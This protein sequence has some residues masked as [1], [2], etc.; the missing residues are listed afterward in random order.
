[1]GAVWSRPTIQSSPASLDFPLTSFTLFP[2]LQPEVRS[3][4]WRHALPGPRWFEF[5]SMFE[6]GDQIVSYAHCKDKKITLLA[7]NHES[8]MEVL[9]EYKQFRTSCTGCPPMYISPEID[10]FCFS[11]YR[12]MEEMINCLEYT[13]R[14]IPIR[15]LATQEGINRE[16]LKRLELDELLL[17]DSMVELDYGDVGIVGFEDG[18][19]IEYGAFEWLN[20][21]VELVTELEQEN[22]NWVAPVIRM[23]SWVLASPSEFTHTEEWLRRAWR[24]Y[25]KGVLDGTIERDENDNED[26]EKYLSYA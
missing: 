24:A 16:W 2:K 23:G 6:P 21:I 11:S 18:W 8:R 19:T 9:R 26:W 25:G 10:V 14:Q 7:V 3:M 12:N 15:R 5:V 1:M 22:P 13:I 20:G 17:V 4:V